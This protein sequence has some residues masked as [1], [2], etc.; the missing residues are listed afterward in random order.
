MPCFRD[1]LFSLFKFSSPSPRTVR[2]RVFFFNLKSCISSSVLNSISSSTTSTSSS[3]TFPHSSLISSSHLKSKSSFLNSN[4]FSSSHNSSKLLKSIN[5]SFLN[6]RSLNN[7]FIH[8]FKLLSDSNLDFLVLSETW[9]ESASS[10][11]LISACPPSY[12]FFELARASQNPLSTSFFTY[13]GICLF[14]KSTF[15]SSKTSHPN[16]KFFES[17]VSSFKFGTLTLFIAVIY[18]PP[19]SSLSS[20]IND[21]SALLEFLYTLSFPFYIVGDFNIQFNIK[22][23]FYTNKFLELL[24]LFNLSQH[25]HFPS[26]SSATPLI[27][28]SHHP[29]SNPL[30]FLLTQSPFLITTSFPASPNK[31]SSTVKGSTRSWS[32]LNKTLFIQLLSASSFDSSSFTD[33]DD[34]V[35]ALNS[36][37]TNTLNVLL[38][39][40]SFTYHLSSFKAPWFDGERVTSKRT[41]RKLERSYRSSPSSS[42]HVL[43]LSHL[44]TYRSL[45]HSKHSNF[46]ISSINSASS[47][48]S[49]WQ[50]LNRIL[51][52][53]SPPPPFSSQD[54]HDYFHNKILSIRTNRSSS[55]TPQASP[56]ASV[57]LSNFSPS[58]TSSPSSNLYL[59]LPAPLTLFFK[60]FLMIFPLSS[61]PLFSILLAF[62]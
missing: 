26:H 57:S 20:F 52:K 62:L 30:V 59:Y 51:S 10:P 41:L 21:F 24:E 38:P 42:S 7:K 16:F 58:Q 28:S 40:K 25:C 60:K 2:R 4:S 45:L 27:F 13:G 18:R 29:L 14:Y 6:I 3:S 11:S 33:L 46:F 32:Q 1:F 61:I 53:Q 49:R 48:S 35:L 56:F 44:S 5:I 17:F 50:N 22:T 39:I 23:N 31:L 36:L 43:W 37:L 19:S 54:F 55:H 15:S 8:V 9:H 34:F 12:S 47:S